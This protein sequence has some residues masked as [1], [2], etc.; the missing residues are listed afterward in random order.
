MSG[1]SLSVTP[2]DGFPLKSR[3]AP[4][5]E[6]KGVAILLVVI[7][8]GTAVLGVG[9]FLHGEVGVDIFLILSGLT[10]SAGSEIRFGE[11][12][13]RRL[14]RIVP[15]YWIVLTLFILGGHYLLSDHYTYGNLIAHY[16][17]IHAL[18]F[19]RPNIFF[20]LNGSFWF[21]S[22]LW[23]T[24]PATYLLRRETDIFKIAAYG[25][26]LAVLLGGLYR[27]FDSPGIYLVP[28]R[29]L[30][31]FAGLVTARLFTVRRVDFDER[32]ASYAAITLFI[33]VF[34]QMYGLV[35]LT[36]TFGGM[37]ITLA[38]LAGRRW[39]AGLVARVVTAP[40]AAIGG[41][42]YELFLLHQPLI[43]DYPMHL[44]SAMGV[45]ATKG[46]L[47]LGVVGGLAVAILLSC[48]INVLLRALFRGE[49]H[50]KARVAGSS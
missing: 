35:T 37:A 28:G 12:A 7:Y 44:M 27:H 40:L 18:V 31:F 50:G 19:S 3:F 23:I 22:L 41:I 32:D 43:A 30:S 5:D 47:L 25:T 46:R 42:S 29:V 26:F 16:L 11:F 34:G 36:Q 1:C 20:S 15:A 33:L 21:L 39:I 8:H 10:L 4:F 9:G 6:L 14:A 24:Y 2:P 48:A 38:Y 49:R 45:E 13:R 17:G